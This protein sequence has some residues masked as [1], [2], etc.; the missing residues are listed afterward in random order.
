VKLLFAKL[1]KLLNLPKGIQLFVMRFFQNQFLVGVTGVIFNEKNEVLLFKHT[2]RQ[3]A[4]SLPGGYLKAGEHPAEALEREIKEESH[5]VVSVDEPLKTRT[6]RTGARLDM[7]YTG[8]FIGGEFTP[9]EE[10]SAYGFFSQDTMPLLRSNQVFLI[11]E[12]LLAK[13]FKDKS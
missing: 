7:C 12:A 10:V 13:K 11:E 5:L 2:Y 8:I 3:H 4:W 1:W 6:D 9:S